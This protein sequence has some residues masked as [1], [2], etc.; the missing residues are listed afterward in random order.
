[1]SQQV[2]SLIAGG[3]SNPVR[4]V[5]RYEQAP[6]DHMLPRH[7]TRLAAVHAWAGSPFSPVLHGSHGPHG[8]DA[9][10]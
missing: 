10:P 4:R 2:K 5:R 9:L 1:M 6:G 3:Q 8:T 7:L